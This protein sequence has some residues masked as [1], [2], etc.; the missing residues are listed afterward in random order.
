[1]SEEEDKSDKTAEGSPKS[2][3]EPPASAPAPSETAAPPES[4]SD[5]KDAP[6]E[7]RVEK[8][9]S[10][11]HGYGFLAVSSAI[12]L[13]LDLGTKEW[14][15]N[16]LEGKNVEPIVVIEGIEALG[17]TFALHFD[18]A[19]NPGGA[20]GVLGKQPDWVRLPFFFLISALAVVFI[21]S[22]YRKLEERQWALRWALPLVLG[23]ALGNLVDRIRHQHVIDFIDAFYIEGGKATHWPTFNVADIWIVAGVILM[24]IDWFTPKAKPRKV[25]REPAPAAGD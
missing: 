5:K 16:R 11:K 4:A 24:G 1:V 17:K 8:S 13:A 9:S 2:E 12:M 7:K 18:L 25:E 23:G 21:V 3:D 22:L 15:A 14:A 19:K 10:P 6:S 20:W